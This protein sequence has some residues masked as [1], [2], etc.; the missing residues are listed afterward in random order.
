MKR[1]TINRKH[2][3]A[4]VNLRQAYMKVPNKPREEMTKCEEALL[5]DYYACY[6]L[7][8]HAGYPASMILSECW[9]EERM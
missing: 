6:S 4:F 5:S 3:S 9:K 1:R 7:L 2:L 8:Q